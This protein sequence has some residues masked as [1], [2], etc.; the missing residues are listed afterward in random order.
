VDCGYING[1]HRDDCSIGAPDDVIIGIKTVQASLPKW[2]KDS[3]YPDEFNTQP[4]PHRHYTHALTHAMKALGG[5]S[6][7]SDALDHSRMN[8]HGA[9][10]DAEAEGFRVDAGKWLADLVICSTRMAEQL[11]IDLDSRVQQRINVLVARWGDK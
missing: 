3:T 5:L 9:D 8:K 11:G 7:L 4:A 1:E 10:R 6:A 2:W